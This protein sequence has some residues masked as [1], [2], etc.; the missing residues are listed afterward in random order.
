M[1]MRAGASLANMR[2][3]WWTPSLELPDGDGVMQTWFAHSE[4]S[5]PHCIMVNRGGRRFANEAANYNSFGAAFHT[6]DTTVYD[7]V[8]RP[9]WLVFDHHY[10]TRYGIHGWRGD[11]PVPGWLTRASTLPALAEQVGISPDGLV[12]TVER[13]GTFVA[14]GDDADFGRGRSAYDLWWS[15]PTITDSVDCTLGAIET[16]PFYAL[17]VTSGTLGTKGGPRTDVDAQVLDVDGAPIPGL[18][19]AGNVMASAMGMTY[20]GAGGTLGPGMAFGYLGGRHAAQTVVAA[21][22]AATATAD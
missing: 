11:G 8:N 20:G 15:D 18:Y 3:A 9:A 5:L 4:A 22:R 6:I 19:A 21:R 17:E 13:Y 14:N 10:V 1:A 7:Y 16:P 12:A 2:E